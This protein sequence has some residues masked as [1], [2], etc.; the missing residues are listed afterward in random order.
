MNNISLQ[1]DFSQE[2]MQRLR[3]L[4]ATSEL[5]ADVVDNPLENSVEMGVEATLSQSDITGQELMTKHI[6]KHPSGLQL[7]QAYFKPIGSTLESETDESKLESE[8]LKSDT[9]PHI[10]K[11]RPLIYVN[12]SELRLSPMS[13]PVGGGELSG[14]VE[15]LDGPSEEVRRIMANKLGGEADGHPDSRCSSAGSRSRRESINQLQK[16]QQLVRVPRLGAM[17]RELARP[18]WVAVSTRNIHVE[19][20][21]ST[22][23]I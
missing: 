16:L 19:N 18:R 8:K 12:D 3:M 4:K 5:Q 13:P 14:R 9:T 17:V 22:S 10:L 6:G 11:P 23:C 20:N 7:E 21:S 1:Q 15:P 2:M